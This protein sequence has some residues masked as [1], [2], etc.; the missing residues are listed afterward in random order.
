MTD[1]TY[2]GWDAFI[3]RAQELS[4]QD[5]TIAWQFAWNRWSLGRHC[6][7]YAQ[8][9]GIYFDGDF[10]KQVARQIGRHESVVYNS[11]RVA[12]VFTTEE[13]FSVVLEQHKHFTKVYDHVKT[14]FPRKETALSEKNGVSEDIRSMSQTDRRLESLRE[15]PPLDP[16]MRI[17][18]GIAAASLAE[19]GL[20]LAKDMD[21]GVSLEPAQKVDELDPMS[22]FTAP[23]TPAVLNACYVYILQVGGFCFACGPEIVHDEVHRAHFPEVRR[24]GSY[25]ILLC[26]KHH[27][28]YVGSQH[29]EGIKTFFSDHGFM[30]LH[31]QQVSLVRWVRELMRHQ[32]L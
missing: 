9:H 22:V 23:F 11:M 2:P 20:G 18:V 1:I 19:T 32:G 31:S 24:K 30:I 7:N 16:D 28:S 12:E 5:K 4:E 17:E 8:E 14:T 29:E 26:Q 25:E 3:G 21:V 6:L 10:P 13:A 15:H 27:T